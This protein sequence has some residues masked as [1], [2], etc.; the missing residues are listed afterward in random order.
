MRTVMLVP[1]RADHGW[2]DQLAQF[3]RT[4]WQ[5]EHPDIPYFSASGPIDGPFNRSA[6][7]NDA[8]AVAGP[9]DVAVIGDSD[10][11]T[12]IRQVLDAV[13]AARRMMGLVIAHDHWRRLSH[14]GT[15]RIVVGGAEPSSQDVEFDLHLTVSSMIAVH[16]ELW[17][18]VRGFDPGFE[19]WG[20][21][22]IAFHAA[23][24][25]LGVVLRVQ[26]PVWHLWHPKGD[27]SETPEYR[28][29]VARMNRYTACDDSRSMAKLIAELRGPL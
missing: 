5:V 8:A 21:E 2:R 7:I 20:M 23:C 15:R 4:R 11:F 22:D 12:N 18:A 19:G 14:A 6:A 25:R 26:G 16:R 1:H 27:A 29:N 17:E 24:D 13:G 3:T 9:W 28:A 10:S